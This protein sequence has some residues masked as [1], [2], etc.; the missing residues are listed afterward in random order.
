MTRDNASPLDHAA[1]CRVLAPAKLNLFLRILAREQ[2]GFH[3]IETLFCALDLA[4]ELEL[5][6]GGSDVALDVRAPADA[7]GRAPDLGPTEANLVVRA[8]RLF[9]AAARCDA[10]VHI[11]LTKRIPTGA[12]L[13][14]GSSDA[15]AVLTALNR[16]HDAPLSRAGLLEL[17]A[18]LGSD[19]PF[20]VTGAALALA[21][22]RGQRLAPLP[23]L[24]SRP[25]LLAIPPERSATAD[26]YAELAHARGTAATGA[27]ALE[28]PR[29]WADV[30]AAE[31]NDFEPTVFARLPRLR[32]LREELARH[33]AAVARMTGSGSVVFGV[34]EDVRSAELARAALQ[35]EHADVELLLTRT[36]AVV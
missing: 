10:G 15:A 25:V 8:A 33:G 27:A 28:L 17:S 35:R 22:G 3:Q 23:P 16:M 14:G 12:G 36:A 31:G 20:F 9:T 32:A 19:V 4:D 30:A 5:R 34:F 1:V 29:T 24:P 7:P 2:S 6:L 13:G 26:A 11:T 18:E 21:W